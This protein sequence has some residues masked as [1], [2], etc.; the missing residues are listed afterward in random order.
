MCIS[1]VALL[2]CG[3]VRIF[4]PFQFEISMGNAGNTIDGQM[5]SAST[6]AAAAALAAGSSSKD[7]GGEGDDLSTY[8]EPGIC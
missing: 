6:P 3:F 7:I 2:K 4:V 1:S 8:E 5:I